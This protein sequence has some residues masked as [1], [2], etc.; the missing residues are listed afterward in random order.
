MC[1]DYQNLM[2]P[3][4]LR[5]YPATAKPLLAFPSADRDWSWWLSGGSLAWISAAGL[6]GTRP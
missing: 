2:L 6:A 5:Q 1:L 3:Y 4:R